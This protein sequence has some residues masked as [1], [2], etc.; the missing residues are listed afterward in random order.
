M[1]LSL[2][3]SERLVMFALAWNARKNSTSACA[4]LAKLAACAGLSEVQTRRILKSLE[5]RGWIRRAAW[6]GRAVT[7]EL[8][9]LALSPDERADL[10]PSERAPN[11]RADLSPNE[12]ADLSR[13]ETQRKE[14]ENSLRSAQRARG[15]GEYSVND[16]GITFSQDDRRDEDC[17]S[18]ITSHPAS[19]I[20]WA[21]EAARAA[22]PRGRAFPSAVLKI[23]QA[24]R[25]ASLAGSNT[26][27][28][29]DYLN[30]RMRD[31]SRE[32]MVID[33]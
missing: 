7:W 33:I 15:R 23:L 16:L 26:A 9:F 32:T 24:G 11:E 6:S 13:G 25:S 12:R 3:G 10:S 28:A 1:A 14:K 20:R 19:E 5:A 2:R 18:L 4:S 8:T 29:R 17:L 21:V 27:T 30:K 31:L 22:E